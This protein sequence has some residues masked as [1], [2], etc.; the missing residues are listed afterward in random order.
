MI[1]RG[2]GVLVIDNDE[3]KLNLKQ[4]IYNNDDSLNLLRIIYE[5]HTT[6]FI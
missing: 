1:T 3:K 6:L 5:P 4:L 2:V